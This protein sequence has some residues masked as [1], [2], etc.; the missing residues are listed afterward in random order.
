MI[1]R[2]EEKKR[3]RGRLLVRQSPSPE[4]TEEIKFNVKFLYSFRTE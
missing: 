3:K 1:E 2:R 4:T